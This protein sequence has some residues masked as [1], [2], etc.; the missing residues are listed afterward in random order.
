MEKKISELSQFAQEYQQA[1]DA[2]FRNILVMA[3]AL[4]GILISLCK[5]DIPPLPSY[6]F[7]VGLSLLGLGIL[8]GAIVL[9]RPTH[10][11]N[12]RFRAKKELLL[13]SLSGENTEN[14]LAGNAS[15]VFSIAEGLAYISFLISVFSFIGY[16]V[17]L[18]F[19]L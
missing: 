4:F 12:K 8:F 3:S 1:V 17:C 2:W 15:I 7:V 6:F 13:R 9:Y 11:A 10:V 14:I 16:I 5:T 18:T 19:K